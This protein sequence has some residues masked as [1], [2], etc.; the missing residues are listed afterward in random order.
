MIVCH[1]NDIVALNVRQGIRATNDD[2]IIH[3]I[4]AQRLKNIYAMYTS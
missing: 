2:Q 1:L 4:N 3:C